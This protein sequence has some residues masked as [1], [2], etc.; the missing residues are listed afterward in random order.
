[1]FISHRLADI[2]V[3][4]A[5]AKYLR[6]IVG[7][8]VYFSEADARL[9]HAV[10]SGDDKKIVQYIEEGIAASSHLIGVISNSTKGSWWVPFEIGGGRQQGVKIAQIL[11]AEVKELPSYLRVA[12]ILRDNDD[13][14]R[15]VKEEVRSDLLWENFSKKSELPNIPRVPNYRY[16]YPSYV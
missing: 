12:K 11:L 4:R 2:D 13:L 3:A 10:R 9:Q 1:M 16:D 8:N 14:R 5:I 6:E 15:W 7:V